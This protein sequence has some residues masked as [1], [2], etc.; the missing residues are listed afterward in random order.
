MKTIQALLD[1]IQ[2]LGIKFRLEGDKLGVKA[3]K[4]VLTDTL[5]S[6]LSARKAEIIAYLQQL[7]APAAAT[8][9]PLVTR[10]QPLPLSFSQ[11]RLWLLH[12]LADQKQVYN[13]PCIWRLQGELVIAALETSINQIVAR[14]ENL[15]TVF[16]EQD[17]TL[18]QTILPTVHV[19]LQVLTSSSPAQAQA[20]VQHLID[21]PFRLERAPLLQAHLLCLPAH[22]YLL[23]LNLHHI[24]ADGW[25][26]DVLVTELASLYSAAVQGS[27]AELPALPIQYADFAYWQR[28]AMQRGEYARPLEYWQQQLTDVPALLNL[29]TDR[30]RPPLQSNQGAVYDAVL[31]PDLLAKLKTLAMQTDTTL[32]M[33]LQAAFAVLLG[34]YAGQDD[35]LLGSPIANRNRLETEGLIGC[36]INTLVLRTR[37]EGNPSFTELLAQVRKTTLDAYQHQDLPFDVL[38]ETL[39]RN[40]PPAIHRCFRSCWYCRTPVPKVYNCPVCKLP[41]KQRLAMCPRLI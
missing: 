22:E 36:F 13:I 17:G 34:R 40:V 21:T 20:Q 37:L 2:A 7:Q 30:P 41:C 29:P 3:A 31:S 11:Q 23:V 18:R 35:V 4:G 6:E 14:H 15:R 26:L 38:V 5:R 27:V 10:N 24:I 12:Q 28:Q 16:V 33:V 32:F 9:I 8:S 1:E 25:S 39:H 19:P